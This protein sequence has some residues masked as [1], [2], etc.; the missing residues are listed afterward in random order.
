MPSQKVLDAG[1]RSRNFINSKGHP[2]Y[3]TATVLLDQTVVLSGGRSN[4]GK[5]RGP[6]QSK[7]WDTALRQC[8]DVLFI[9]FLR[10]CLVWDA[11]QRMTPPQALQHPWIA[12]KS[13]PP[14]P[15]V[16]KSPPPAKTTPLN[17][18][19]NNNAV[20]VNGNANGNVVQWGGR[21]VR[22]S[23]VQTFRA[24]PNASLCR[25]GQQQDECLKLPIIWLCLHFFPTNT[26][27]LHLTNVYRGVTMF[28]YWF[29]L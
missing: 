5:L 19:L 21:V 4:R 3:C 18:L 20:V 23:H 17:G 26:K 15:D 6:P 11:D 22:P 29:S 28:K 10:R 9:D 7:T 8:S 25:V 16:L 1:K 27:F 12:K 14:T 13:L 24:P 2:R